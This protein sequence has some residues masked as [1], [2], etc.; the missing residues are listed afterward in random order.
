MQAGQDSVTIGKVPIENYNQYMAL[1]FI[2]YMIIGS[3]LM[4]NLFVGVVFESFKKEKNNIGKNSGFSLVEM[5]DFRGALFFDKKSIRM[6]RYSNKHFQIKAYRKSNKILTINTL[7]FYPKEKVPTN[8]FRRFFYLLVT[9]SL[10]EKFII[11]S[12]IAN[13]L[14]FVLYWNRQPAS[15]NKILTNLNLLFITIFTFE[16]V[17]KIIALGT[18]YFHSGWNILDFVVIILGIIGAALDFFISFDLG[19]SSSIIRTFRIGRLIRLLKKAKSLNLIFNTLLLTLPS[20]ANIGSLLMLGLFIFS[21]IAMNNFAF[22]KDGNEINEKANFRSF[23]NSFFTLLR[24][25]TGE[26]W[27]GILVDSVAYQRPDFVCYQIKDY[28][29]FLKYG[30]S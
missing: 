23:S 1:Y 24:I 27:D 26:N 12:I 11:L 19:S 18:A 30:K 17:A 16:A 9:N 22:L 5:I 7:L 28:Y 4:L 21:I 29:D 10:F 20:L 15:F 2:V 13:A 3:Y 14:V 8:K 6:D 25:S